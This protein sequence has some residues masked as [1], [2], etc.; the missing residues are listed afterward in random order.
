MAAH[1]LDSSLR[2]TA[3]ER[4]DDDFR[5]NAGGTGGQFMT[6]LS[7]RLGLEV[8]DER[9]KAE[10]FYATDLLVRHGSGNA[11][12]D[13]RGGVD[14]GYALSRRLKVDF[15]GKLFR[16]TDP[17]SLPRE[18]VARSLA[19]T[20]YGQA[21]VAVSERAT[22]RL[23][24][25][26][27]Y[28]FEGAKEYEVGR[29]PGFVAHPVRRGLVPGHAAADAGARVPLPELPLRRR[30]LPR[31]RRL[32]GPALPVDSADDADGARRA[33]AL[34][35][36]RREWPGGC[37]A[38]RWSWSGTESARSGPHRGTR[39]G[40]RQRLHQRAVGGLRVGGGVPAIHGRLSAHAAASFF[41]NGRAPGEGAFRV[42]DSPYVSQGYAVGGS[43]EYRL[44]RYL[45]LQGA[46]DRIAQVGAADAAAAADLARNVFALRSVDHGLVVHD[47][48]GG[49]DHGA[50][51]DGGPG[52][53]RPCGAARHWWGRSL[54]R[55][56]R[57]ARPS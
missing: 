33:R 32:R 20:L 51:D 36:R 21:R 41:R 18:G 25:R 40:G 56:S 2:L 10:G 17:T 50:W 34:H 24:L 30:V 13:H 1:V 57:W 6:K 9:T 54:Q 27:S 11:T 45:T 47:G 5:L 42:S 31:A 55:C 4:Y 38:T 44:T 12:L 52:A 3:E 16:V 48:G 26:A 19:P 35:L 53:W 14:L 46:V 22:R 23:D 37:P 29:M 8:K 28:A 7:P 43:V 49:A 15:T 39:P